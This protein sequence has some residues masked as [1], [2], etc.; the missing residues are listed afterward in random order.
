MNVEKAIRTTVDTG[1]V[2]FGERETLRAVRNKEIRL[3]IL[4]TN[5]PNGLKD[6]L[7]H[8]AKLSGVYVY[9]FAGPSLELGAVC[10]KPFVISMLGVVDAGDSDIFELSR[11]K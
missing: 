10:G 8:Y 1:K 9:E 6:D 2:I 4:A 7:K 5:C 11:R 3:V